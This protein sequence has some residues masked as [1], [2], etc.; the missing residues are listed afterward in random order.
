[1]KDALLAYRDFWGQFTNPLTGEMIPAFPRG[2]VIMRGPESPPDGVRWITP[3]PPY[4]VFPLDLP[5]MLDNA[6][7]S[8]MIWDRRPGTPGYFDL[9]LDVLAQ[10]RDRINGGIDL[11]LDSGSV[12]TLY[13]SNSS[14]MTEP[15]DPTWV[16]GV[17]NLIIR[18]RSAR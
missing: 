14:T 18:N 17:Q 3:P 1:M 11:K 10:I 13:L 4:I 5:A 9:A 6:V 8:V 15:D 2:A 12:V 7:V 16:R